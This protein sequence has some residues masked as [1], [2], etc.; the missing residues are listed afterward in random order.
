M[1]NCFTMGKYKKIIVAIDG[2]DA[3]IHALRESFRL[4]TNEKSWITVVAVAPPYEGD[5][6]MVGVGNVLSAMRRP[7]EEAL[8]RAREIASRDRVLIKTVLEEGEPYERIVDLATSENGDIIIMGRKGL[9]HLD[10]ALIGS[11][12]ARVIG[13]SHRDILVVP[14]NTA[15]GWENILVATDG[16]RFSNVAVEHAINFAKDY[17]GRLKVLSVVNVPAEAYGES[18]KL[19]DDLVNR[20]RGYVEAVG[21][22][23]SDAGIPSET[24]VKETEEAYQAIIQIAKEQEINTIVMG[25]HGRTGLKRLLMGSVTEKVIGNAPCPVLVVKT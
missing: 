16:S 13:Y 15:V 2:S 21:K 25:S 8:S 3:S 5:L 12:T 9:T 20:G 18:P 6:D 7:Y 1:Q 11:V 22:K 4:G 23:A 19:V 17:E 24:F 14:N 10:K